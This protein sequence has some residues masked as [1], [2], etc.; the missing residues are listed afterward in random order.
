MKYT[1]IILGIQWKMK[2]FKIYVIK[3]WNYDRYSGTGKKKVIAILRNS[4]IIYGTQY[5]ATVI[6]DIW[7]INILFS[8]CL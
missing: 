7:K 3:K 2:I 5:Y 8:M 1:F 4:I 6:W